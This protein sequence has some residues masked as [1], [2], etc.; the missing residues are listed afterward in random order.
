MKSTYLSLFLATASASS[1]ESS[2]KSGTDASDGLKL[3]VLSGED[4][5]LDGLGVKLN[6]KRDDEAML[7]DLVDETGGLLSALLGGASALQSS[8]G[9][10]EKRGDAASMEDSIYEMILTTLFESY[11]ADKSNTEGKEAGDGEK[12]KEKREEAANLGSL[13]SGGGLGDLLENILASNSNVEA[14]G[15]AGTGAKEGARTGAKIEAMEEASTGETTGANENCDNAAQVD[16]T[17]GE[18]FDEQGGLLSVLLGGASAANSNDA[19]KEGKEKRDASEGLDLSML[20]GLMSQADLGYLLGNLR[21]S[22]GANYNEKRDESG[23]EKRDESGSEGDLDLS[24]LLSSD[25]IGSLLGGLLSPDKKS[26]E[27]RDNSG[28]EGNLDLSS[29]LSSGLVEQVSGGLMSGSGANPNQKHD[30][31][32]NV[33]VKVNLGSLLS[34]DIVKSLLGKLGGETAGEQSKQ[35]V[36]TTDQAAAE[37]QSAADAKAEES[38]KAQ[39]ENV[40]AEAEEKTSQK[41]QEPEAETARASGERGEARRGQ[42]RGSEGEA[43]GG[44]CRAQGG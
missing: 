17:L 42:G 25:L 23:N 41:S 30:G 11:L 20:G 8:P 10:K 31:S 4:G 9:S 16:K 18:L 33:D 38:Q 32:A 28:S 44:R 7:E 27:K 12:S 29:L 14:K 43:S 21:T 22:A 1:V 6:E 35:P 39:K 40:K 2:T 19:S 3:D 13:V 34:S 26:N 36:A 37:E 24:S 5:S 15:D